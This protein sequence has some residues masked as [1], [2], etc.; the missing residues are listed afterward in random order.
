MGL[1]RSRTSFVWDMHSDVN[2]A[3]VEE[4]MRYMGLPLD[5]AVSAFLEDVRDRGLSDKIM[6]L[7]A[8]RWA[9]EHRES[10]SGVVATIGAVWLHC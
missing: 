3:G 7:S 9:A 5:Y 6:R 2:N 1:S 4:G 8:E 10:M